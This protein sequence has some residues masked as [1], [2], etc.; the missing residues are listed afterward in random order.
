LTSVPPTAKSCPKVTARLL[1]LAETAAT[2]RAQSSRAVAMRE[3]AFFIVE[4]L[5]RLDVFPNLAARRF[6]VAHRRHA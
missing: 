4:F 2:E 6:R 1:T 3:V 5:S